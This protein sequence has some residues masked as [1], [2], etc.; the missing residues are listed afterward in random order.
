MWYR[1]FPPRIPANHHEILQEYSAYYRGLN[2]Q[3]KQRFLHRLYL[4]IRFTRF[5]PQDI[6]KVT[7]AMKVL[8]GS[9]IVQIAFG[10]DQYIFRHFNKIFVVPRSYTYPGYPYRM[11]GD[12]NV[13]D[14]SVSL[15]WPHVKVGFEIT[16]DAHN[17]ALHEIAHC[18]ILE[19]RFRIISDAFIESE[20]WAKWEQDSSPIF[21][22]LQNGEKKI[23]HPY[24][25]SNT[26]EF[27]AV[28]V[29]TFFE[30][31]NELKEQEPELYNRLAKLLR[32]DPMNAQN[33]VITSIK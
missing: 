18:L 7:L 30:K 14:K 16:D 9:A 33:P 8:I 13:Y 5:I 10:L 29:E 4:V 12:V 20:D 22:A 28:C 24:G 3:N 31:S 15:S 26:M 6:P 19:D 32:Q 1:Q 23:L 11:V 17:I 25:G 2:D 27:F 21:K